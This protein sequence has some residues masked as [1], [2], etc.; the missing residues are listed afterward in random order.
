MGPRQETRSARVHFIEV[1]VGSSRATSAFVTTQTHDHVVVA[2]LPTRGTV[3]MLGFCHARTNGGPSGKV[4]VMQ[5]F[6]LPEL[7]MPWPARL[8]LHLAWGSARRARRG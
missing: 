2:S 4:G 5:P 1:S 3:P 8:N 7:F 6:E